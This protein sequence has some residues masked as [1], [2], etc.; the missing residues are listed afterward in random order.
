MDLEHL[1]EDHLPDYWREAWSCAKAA[2]HGGADYFV[3]RCFAEVVRDRM[4]NPLDVDAAMDM[5]LPGLV[6]QESI[7][8]GGAWL[9]VPD[10]RE[11]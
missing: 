8:Q 7:R 6:S 2:G 3:A 10:S 4:P 5:T 1:A 11:W 9:P